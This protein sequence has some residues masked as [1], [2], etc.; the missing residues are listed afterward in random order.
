VAA[1]ETLGVRHVEALH[2]ATEIGFRGL[3]EQVIVV[4]HQAIGVAT[5]MVLFDLASEQ[6]EKPHAVGVVGE[7]ILPGIATRS[8]VIDGAGELKAELAGHD[9]ILPSASY[10]VK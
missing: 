2:P 4:A 10:K 7:D 3:D 6:V 5:P 8:H 9:R 1:V